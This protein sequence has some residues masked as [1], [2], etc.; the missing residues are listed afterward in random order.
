[1]LA[2]LSGRGWTPVDPPEPMDEASVIARY[3]GEKIRAG[4]TTEVV[5][6]S[7]DVVQEKYRSGKYD[8]EL[9]VDLSIGR[10]LIKVDEAEGYND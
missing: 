3:G 1:M 10:G 4:L 7:E 8:V 9:K 2:E 5:E 6:S